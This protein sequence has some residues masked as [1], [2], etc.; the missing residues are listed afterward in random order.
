MAE[1]G[2]RDPRGRFPPRRQASSDDEGAEEPAAG[3]A[4]DPPS[5]DQGEVDISGT[6]APSVGPQ[7]TFS[8]QSPEERLAGHEQSSVDAMGLD[9]R[10]PV[11]GRRYSPSFARQATIYGVF[12]AV[13]AVLVVGFIILAGKLD[14]PP[15]TN[16]DVAPWSREDAA[17]Q[18]PAPIDFPRYGR[19]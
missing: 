10:R 3:Q 4:G 15:E 14:E 1:E 5:G 6:P 7:T 13:V 11:V 19:N 18:P 8:K 12:L 16:P 9:K 17:Q 2:N